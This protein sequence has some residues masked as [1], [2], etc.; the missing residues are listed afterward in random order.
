MDYGKN[1]KAALKFLRGN[2][3]EQTCYLFLYPGNA[4]GDL[5]HVL[6]VLATNPQ[7]KVLVI[8]GL[9]A[10][11]MQATNGL[12][13]IAQVM[14][15]QFGIPP[16][17]VARAISL[18]KQNNP[19]QL[20]AAISDAKSMAAQSQPGFDRIY[21]LADSSKILR[22]Q[23]LGDRNPGFSDKPERLAPEI[24][25]SHDFGTVKKILYG[26]YGDDAPKSSIPIGSFFDII[27][28]AGVTAEDMSKPLVVLWGRRA[29]KPD[30]GGV[31]YDLNHSNYAWAQLSRECLSKGLT[32]FI[33][34][35]FDKTKWEADRHNG[36]EGSRYLGEFY[37]ARSLTR[38]MQL[39]FFDYIREL[40]EW[41]GGK[42]FLHVGMRS[43]GLDFYGFAG[44]P[45]LYIAA[46]QVSNEGKRVG[47]ERMKGI[48]KALSAVK[49]ASYDRFIAERVPK[50]WV[51][52]GD[53]V[54]VDAK[55]KPSAG[56]EKN[57]EDKG[58]TDSDLA[59][60]VQQIR[61]RLAA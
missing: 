48:T 28:S 8:D 27:R 12:S 10:T 36:F 57:D 45:V 9:P 61:N 53:L 29:G 2:N 14:T 47:D 59:A 35:Q 38:S 44:Q 41:H 16:N 4:T 60:L 15:Q 19:K 54:T 42:R 6:P 22:A 37:T 51:T 7:Y 13:A 18:D 33:A 39:C 3:G 1:I 58:F 5:P 26:Q 43:G 52:Q 24:E 34:G 55:R 49:G 21:Q 50:R 11:G 23:F 40:L 56:G 17:Q 46:E 32:V 30:S 31:H 25:A 20:A